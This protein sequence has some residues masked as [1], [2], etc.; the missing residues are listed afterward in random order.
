MSA[1]DTQRSYISYERLGLVSNLNGVAGGQ[2]KKYPTKPEEVP[3]EELREIDE[4]NIEE[5]KKSLKPG[6]G[7]IQRDDEG[8][9]IR[10][11]VGE[12]K[13]HNEKMD[14]DPAPVEAKTDVVRG[15][16][17]KGNWK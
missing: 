7:L 9:V 12:E 16:V 4:S 2:N 3:E 17:K 11:I 8:N 13:T 10:V 6:E 15:N 14:Y 5:I 1:K